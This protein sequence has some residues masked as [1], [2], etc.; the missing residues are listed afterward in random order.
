MRQQFNVAG[1][2]VSATSPIDVARRFIAALVVAAV[3][4]PALAAATPQQSIAKT[5]AEAQAARARIDDLTARFEEA[6]EE[7]FAVEEELAATR[8]KIRLAEVDLEEAVAEVDAAELQLNSR[9][10][11]IYRDGKLDI[12]SVFF[13]VTDF[14]DFVTRMDLLRRIGRNDAVMVARVKTAKANAEKIRS[15]LENRRLEQS[16]LLQTASAKRSEV[17][18][19]LQAQKEYLAGI[20][21]RLKT[22]IAEEQARRAR[23]AREQAARAAAAA[24]A[25]AAKHAPIRE[26]NEGALPGPTSAVVDIARQFVGKTPYVW[27]GT[28]PDGFDCSGL[29]QYCY[30]QIGIQ[31]PRTSRS[32]FG[33][34]AFIPADRLDLLMPGDL[35]F[36]GT[37]GDPYRVH[38]VGIYSGDGNFIHAPYSGALVSENSLIERID[39]RGDY[40]GAARMTAGQ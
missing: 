34:G 18:L 30:G 39:S 10:G 13:G 21:K 35:V 1:G 36:F 26:F 33:S 32:Q 9:A 29:T 25:K 2:P 6:S 5:R 40:V 14:K 38:H 20:D 4:F 27:G 7:Y 23:M 24:R 8:Q 37:D 28:T 15:E 17:N 22:L 3:A 16:A 19:A 12:F 11:S 31:L